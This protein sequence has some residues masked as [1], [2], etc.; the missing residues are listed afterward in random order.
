MS[1]LPPHLSIQNWPWFNGSEGQAN[2]HTRHLWELHRNFGGK[3]VDPL[4]LCVWCLR[5][6]S[7][8]KR[9]VKKYLGLWV[10][11]GERHGYLEYWWECNVKARVAQEA[12]RNSSSR[13]I[14]MVWKPACC[15]MKKEIVEIYG[16]YG[17][18]GRECQVGKLYDG[19]LTF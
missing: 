2:R 6:G 1:S 10:A 15:L 7:L 13:M 4:C 16:G 18:G 3:L 12:V 5:P 8:K 9:T 17:N 11:K 14:T 19:C